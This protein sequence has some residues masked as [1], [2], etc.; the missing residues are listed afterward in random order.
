[1]KRRD[2]LGGSLAGGL[3][4]TGLPAMAAEEAA[5]AGALFVTPPVVMAPRPDGVEVRWAVSGL[6]RGWVEWQE[7]EGE[8]SGRAAS[9]PF[10]M[11]PQ[12][13]RI[14]GVRIEG[15][16]PGTAYRLR[17]VV[18]AA[19]GGRRREE[20]EWKPFRTLDPQAG[21]T[22]FLVWNDT[23]ENHETLRRL[24]QGC[25]QADFMV[26]N[27]DTCNDW[28]QEPWLIPTL[29][30]PGGT[31]FTAGRPLCLVWGNHDVRGKWAFKVPECIA[32]PE[33]KPY[34]AL[35]SGPLAALVLHTGEDKPDDHPSFAG[36]VA[37]DTLRQE[38]A[39]WI[40]QVTQRPEI[41]D[42]PWKIVF[43]H[44]PL[45][46]T[47]EVEDVGYERGGYDR[48]SRRSR[49]AWHEALVAWG[50]RLVVSGH[51][52]RPAYLPATAE[53]PYAQLVSGGPR[54][55]QARWIEGSADA[56]KLRL[57]M[58]DLDGAET[59]VVEFS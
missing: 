20:S 57:V 39:E 48:F 7:T 1:M 26:W 9:D 52:H 43:C 31:D 34:Y 22:R 15:L 16:K 37:F 55:E 42:A 12:G 29:M 35:R 30:H 19:D 28:H 59:E 11:V 14:L 21:A 18:E 27:G 49:D 13:E 45:R 54:P 4:A 44:I 33:G 32:V 58:R 47:E 8:G 3:A 38:Q 41:R 10:G 6:C 17:A 24:H 46:W 25:P 51:T 5:A 50:A 36:R 2:F 23:H 40:R 53:F 56:G